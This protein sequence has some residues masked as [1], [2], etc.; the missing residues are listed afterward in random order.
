MGISLSYDSIED[1]PQWVQDAI[2][3]DAKHINSEREWWCEPIWFSDWP[4]DEGKLSGDTKLYRFMYSTHN[5]SIVT[6]DPSDNRFMVAR[7]T[8]FIIQQLVRWSKEYGVNW[9]L[10]M[11]E[12]IGTISDG[13]LSPGV[14]HFV[15]RMLIDNI[16]DNK[17]TPTGTDSDDY[18]RAM[19][20]SRKYASRNN[21]P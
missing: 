13:R 8:R 5:G 9:R 15:Q 12:E 17:V 19:A 14:E 11:E 3:K 20:I 10:I 6:V 1:T 2:K 7:D 18:E 4:E 16:D 21:A